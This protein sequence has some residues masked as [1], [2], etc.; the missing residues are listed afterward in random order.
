MRRPRDEAH[1]V[2]RGLLGLPGADA[3]FRAKERESRASPGGPD[4]SC[5][6]PGMGLPKD[7]G[8]E[9]QREANALIDR[10]R[11]EGR[12]DALRTVVARLL[13]VVSAMNLGDTCD[14]HLGEEIAEREALELLDDPLG[15]LAVLKSGKRDGTVRID[16]FSKRRLAYLAEK[17][18][19]GIASPHP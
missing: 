17:I 15:C 7:G 8:H 9:F 18:D 13:S 5:D 11:L 10:L 14:C 4:R 19:A 16:L 6:T 12:L 3:G 1:R 2:A